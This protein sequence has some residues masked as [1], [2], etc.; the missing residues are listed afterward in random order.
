MV[1]NKSKTSN[2]KIEIIFI[3]TIRGLNQQRHKLLEVDLKGNLYLYKN[4]LLCK[5]EI[6]KRL[7]SG[8]YHLEGES[9][10]GKSHVY[11]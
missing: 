7:S 9:S 10:I 11:D 4:A 1:G 8:K 3:L 5:D 2:V 6:I